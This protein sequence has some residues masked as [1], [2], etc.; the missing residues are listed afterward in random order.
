MAPY[1]QNDTIAPI[2]IAPIVESKAG[3]D[4]SSAS[5]AVPEGESFDASIRVGIEKLSPVK[6][7]L[8]YGELALPSA[9]ENR[10]IMGCRSA[11][12]ASHSRLMTRRM[13][14]PDGS[15]RR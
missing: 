1:K 5:G 10:P 7:P 4:G 8:Y 3:A 15:L 2:S 11:T 9:V 13:W 12:A 14:N 6:R